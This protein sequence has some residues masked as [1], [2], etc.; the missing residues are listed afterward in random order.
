MSYLG[1]GA[2]WRKRN[3]LI[4]P[5]APVCA[6]T[7]AVNRITLAQFSSPGGMITGYEFPIGTAPHYLPADY[8]AVGAWQPCV[9]S[10]GWYLGQTNTVN[11][12]N[13]APPPSNPLTLDDTF[14][15][16]VVIADDSAR[17]SGQTR[18]FE[19]IGSGGAGFG[20]MGIWFT[21]SDFVT[22]KP[23]VGVAMNVGFCNAIGTIR[24]RAYDQFGNLLGTWLNLTS[25]GY[26]DFVINRDS[27]TP[28]IAGVLFD[29][30]DAAGYSVSRIQFSTTCA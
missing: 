21:E 19:G 17:P 15:T 6:N 3:Y 2:D 24:L 1:A 18:C 16:S 8:G 27:N 13:P 14:S 29:S 7:G 28:I 9:S 10:F 30:S 26:E 5:D 25:G 12:V 4:E 23:V 11:L 22:N 20:P